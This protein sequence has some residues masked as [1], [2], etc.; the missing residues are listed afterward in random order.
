MATKRRTNKKRGT[1]RGGMGRLHIGR[2]LAS[3]AT[4]IT[5]K[6]YVSNYV[7]R[8]IL[9]KKRI[10]KIFDAVDVQY[11]IVSVDEKVRS[12]DNHKDQKIV[13]ENR[14]IKNTDIINDFPLLTY[15]E[16]KKNS[17]YKGISAHMLY[18]VITYIQNKIALMKESDTVMMHDFI[19]EL[20]EKVLPG[21]SHLST[22]EPN[23]NKDYERAFLEEEKI[24]KENP[25]NAQS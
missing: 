9:T 15:E 2:T 11:Q 25:L 4:K 14:R 10:Q 5:G 13:N 16:L 8:T 24:K 23:R 17:T 12:Y 6:N 1:K 7:S 20:I 3:L 22:K 21:R 19:S 18:K